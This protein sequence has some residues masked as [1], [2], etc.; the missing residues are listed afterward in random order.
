M[1]TVTLSLFDSQE[2]KASSSLFSCCRK[3]K[4]KS[5]NQ[6]GQ[7][8]LTYSPEADKFHTGTIRN[9]WTKSTFD[10]VITA[11]SITFGEGRK[12]V[13]KAEI[14][15]IVEPVSINA[16]L[17]AFPQLEFMQIDYC[18]IVRGE[19]REAKCIKDFKVNITCP[20][21]CGPQTLLKLTGD[22]NKIKTRGFFAR[23]FSR[24]K[25]T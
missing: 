2:V 23:I 24:T 16:V 8:I 18:K 11:T 21:N 25:K 6:T 17:K 14:R 10:Q 12:F 15:N 4:N 22:F 3:N 20:K 5:Q 7:V 9:I 13:T 1:K 19:K